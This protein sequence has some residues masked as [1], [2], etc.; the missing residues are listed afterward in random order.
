MPTLT[1]MVLDSL[2]DGAETPATM[3]DHGEYGPYGLALFQENAVI[4]AVRGAF[5]DGLIEVD[6]VEWGPDLEQ[7]R[8]RPLA[9]ALSETEVPAD[10]RH[11]WFRLTEGGWKAW[12]DHR[13]VLDAYWGAYWDAYPHGGRPT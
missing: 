6:H 13:D 7:R 9:P 1:V 12:R 2:V 10:V 8:L 11:Y 4:D 5:H 3:R